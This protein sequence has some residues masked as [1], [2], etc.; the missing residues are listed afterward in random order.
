MAITVGEVI[1][2][3]VIQRGAPRVLSDRRWDEPVRWVHVGEVAN[4]SSLLQ[5]GELVLTTGVGFG[6]KP[7]PYLRGLAEAGVL[8]LVV[9]LGTTVPSVDP[10][11]GALAAE[12][13]LALVVLHEQIRFVD[14]TEAVHRRIVAAQFDEVEF[15]RR[16]HETFTEMSMKRSDTEA[17]VR[18]A[19]DIL[20]ETVVLED[21]A[22]Q[23]LAM[24]IRDGAA[25]T[26]LDDW[27]RRSRLNGSSDAAAEGWVTTPVG[28]RGEEWGRLIAPTP[29]ARPGRTTMVLERAA[30]ALALHQ[31]I[32]RN[33]S[34]LH[35]Q[36]QSGFI[37]DV[38]QGRVTDGREIDARA[39]ALGLRAASRYLPLVIRVERTRTK[40]DPVAAQRGNVTLV[41]A[42]AHA[43]QASGHSGLVA[44]RR[45]GE[46]GAVVALGSARG[47]SDR[48]LTALCD[49]LHAAVRRL[50][51]VIHSSCGIAA[52]EVE[53]ADAIGGLREASHVA[54]V[55][56]AM[57][58]R[59]QSFFRASDV[60]LRGLVALLRDDPRVQQFAETE[61][62]PLL[63]DGRNVA[64][65]DEEV[66]RQ[67]LQT[68]GN[69][70]ALAERLHMSRPALYKRL[71][72]ISR[73]LDCDL[74][75]SES[76]TSL[77]VAM[78]VLDARRSSES[79]P[80]A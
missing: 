6:Q 76:M 52:F 66:L 32:E 80:G 59:A 49:R 78:M 42:V 65:S 45:D 46:V 25:A 3:P 34:G 48:A 5:G 23:V 54:E 38:L 36:A 62:R 9:E 72:A 21:L 35:Q 68:S 77:A 43:V 50:D 14:V 30:V 39:H 55:S 4:L 40:P 61:L 69:K 20:G 71:S 18:A 26:L 1:G 7:R 16:V 11:M 31:M 8:G 51:G 63:S 73:R 15:D 60:R 53:V 17:V 41:N 29:S 22:H 47:G 10:A 79:P 13:N 64:P 70:S 75:D 57:Q 44:A 67:Y 27:E 19:S 74:E 37:D 2:L 24:S 58:G 12:L 56:M 33:Q 28:P